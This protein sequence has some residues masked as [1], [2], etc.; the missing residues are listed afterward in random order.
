M[1]KTVID[2]NVI[3]SAIAFG[4]TPREVLNLVITG[5]ISNYVSENILDEL[6]EVLQRPKFDYDILKIRAILYELELVSK[7]VHATKISE[8]LDLVDIPAKDPDDNY[9]I[10]CAIAAEAEYLVTGDN[11]LLVLKEWEK[12]QI[13]TP[14]QFMT[15]FNHHHKP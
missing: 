2:T 7:Y 13:V 8:A 14:A 1:L 12:L 11:D 10:A 4:G 3:I 9:I 5:R 15:I 6:K